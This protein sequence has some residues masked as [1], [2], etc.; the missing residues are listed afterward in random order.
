[1][2]D[3]KH[4]ALPPL[5]P[6][7]YGGVQSVTAPDSPTAH[8]SSPWPRGE[9]WPKMGQSDSFPRNLGWDHRHKGIWA[10]KSQEVREEWPWCQPKSQWNWDAAGKPKTLVC[11]EKWDNKV[12][13]Q[14]ELEIPLTPLVP[15]VP[16]FL[17]R[18]AHE[19]AADA[20]TIPQPTPPH[21]PA[22]PVSGSRNAQMLLSQTTGRVNRD[23]WNARCSSQWIGDEK[24][25][26]EY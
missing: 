15:T 20:L 10:P 25:R 5:L 12:D 6:S 24:D 1:M 23:V 11:R 14:K 8:N 2:R 19:S 3:Q 9:A 7:S 13:G 22:G 18:G 16:C 17:S 4:Q 26:K 21:Q